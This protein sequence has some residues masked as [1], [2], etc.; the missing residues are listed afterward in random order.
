MSTTTIRLPEALKARVTRLAER[1]GTSAHGLILD[2]IAEKADALECRQS[3][4]EEAEARYAEFLKTGL[5][6]PWDEMRAY[7]EAR[8]AG[9]SPSPPV[10]RVISAAYRE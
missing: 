10:A 1:E 3:F 9:E 6:I 5:A 2:A 4:Y 8:M 7:V